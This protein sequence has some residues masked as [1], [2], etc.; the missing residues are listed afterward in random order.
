MKLTEFEKNKIAEE[1]YALVFYVV[2]MFHNTGIAYDD[3]VGAATEGYAKALNA[4]D[5][6]RN[7][8]FSTYAINCIRNEILFFMRKEKRHIVN[9]ISLN[10]ILASDKNGNDLSVEDTIS[11]ESGDVKGL[12]DSVVLKEELEKMMESLD[13]LEDIDKYIIIHRYGLFGEKIKTQSD[14]ASRTNMSQANVSKKEKL[15]LEALEK[16]LANEFNIHNNNRFEEE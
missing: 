16:I 6:G 1:N 14:I 10:K 5:D 3:L 4:Y 12:E 7:T 13:M 8:K 15:I 9:N 11:N 2:N